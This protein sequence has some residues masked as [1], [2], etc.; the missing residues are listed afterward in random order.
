[1]RIREILKTESRK[2]RVFEDGDE[3]KWFYYVQHISEDGG[4]WVDFV[5]VAKKVFK[6][7]DFDEADYEIVIMGLP[8]DDDTPVFISWIEKGKLQTFSILFECR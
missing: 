5:D 6:D 1:M 8:C 4:D 3:S 2:F 7:N